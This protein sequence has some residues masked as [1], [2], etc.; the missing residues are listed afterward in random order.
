MNVSVYI[1]DNDV[2]GNLVTHDNFCCRSESFRLEEIMCV[3]TWACKILKKRDLYVEL[4]PE[5]KVSIEENIYCC[6]IISLNFWFC[7]VVIGFRVF[8]M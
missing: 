1:A 2:P 5:T 6:I 7:A 4:Y 3:C 8:C